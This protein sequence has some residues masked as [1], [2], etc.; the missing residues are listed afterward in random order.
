MKCSE[1]QT[2]WHRRLDEG[3]PDPAL[4]EHLSQCPACRQYDVQLQRML[5][6]VGQ[7][8]AETES[9]IAP[10]TTESTRRRPMKFSVGLR[11]G[12]AVAAAVALSVFVYRT[13]RPADEAVNLGGAIVSRSAS[14]AEPPLGMSLRGESAAQLMAVASPTSDPAVQI[15]WLYPRLDAA[16]KGDQRESATP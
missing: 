10:V 15:F 12:L 11:R 6:V 1:A 5:S 13:P 9:M 3:E 4:D 14:A 8:R 2:R 7:L 16:V